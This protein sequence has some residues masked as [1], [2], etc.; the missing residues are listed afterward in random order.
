MLPLRPADLGLN[1]GP[2]G[3]DGRRSVGLL[4]CRGARAPMRRIMPTSEPKAKELRGDAVGLGDPPSAHASTGRGGVGVRGAASPNSSG[5]FSTRATREARA[6]AA[7][8]ASRSPRVVRAR[9][10]VS[11][12]EW[13]AARA[14][15]RAESAAS[16]AS[17]AEA[18]ASAAATRA[19]A[20]SPASPAAAAEESGGVEG[21]GGNVAGCGGSGGGVTGGGGDG[22][23]AGVVR[24][25]R[26][27]GAT[28]A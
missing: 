16:S 27:I 5:W 14:A 25:S 26:R 8:P 24:G 17:A 12:S 15:N 11:A 20:P 6:S 23:T 19:K 22:G 1:D 4:G 28:M 13:V 9:P 7:A 10:R 2:L 3:E 18:R 21:P